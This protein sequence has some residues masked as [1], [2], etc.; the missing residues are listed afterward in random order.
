MASFSTDVDFWL[1]SCLNDC[2]VKNAYAD[3]IENITNF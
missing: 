2:S 1:L 3:A